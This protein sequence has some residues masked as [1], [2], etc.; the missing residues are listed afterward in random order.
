MTIPENAANALS[1]PLSYEVFRDPVTEENGTCCHTF[2]RE[3][4]LEW[5]SKNQTCP[6]SRNPLNRDQ[7]IS[8]HEVREGSVLLLPN[9][10]NPLTNE[11]RLQVQRAVNL[12]QNR[13]PVSENMHQYLARQIVQSSERSI[14]KS[15]QVSQDSRNY[16]VLL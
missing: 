12:I 10:V 8:N 3:W 7:L 6:I 14:E 4:I 13:D 11:E 16:C 1:C 9:R 2:E 5:L 15:K